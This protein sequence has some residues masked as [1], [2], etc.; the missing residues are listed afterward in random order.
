MRL[1][2][3]GSRARDPRHTRPYGDGWGW[4]AVDG[5]DGG[6]ARG[7]LPAPPGVLVGREA[8]VDRLSALLADGDSPLVTLT[9]PPGVGKT[10]LALAVAARASAG[11]ADGVVFVD[12]TAVREPDLVLPEIAAAAGLGADA[13]DPARLAVV[14]R[15][16]ELLLVLDN[17]EHVLAAA[18]GLATALATCPG[19]RILATSR[20]RLHL[21]AEREVPVAPLALPV[22]ADLADPARVAAAPAVAMLLDRVRRFAPDFA[23]TPENRAA[24]VE[25]CTRLDGLP[26]ALELA[27]AR[28]RL[29]TPSELQFRLARRFDLLTSAVQDGPDRHRTLHAALAWSH[30]LL[31]PFERAVFRR[32]S[33]FVGGWTLPA[34]EAVGLAAADAGRDVVTAVGSLIDKSLVRRRTRAGDVAEFVLLE[35]LREFGGEQLAAHGERAATEARHREHY[36]A[37]GTTMEA[38]LGADDEAARLAELGAEVGNLRAALASATAAGDTGAVLALATAVGWHSYTRGRLGEGRD[39]LGAALAA[40]RDAGVPAGELGRALV[41]TGAIDYARNDLDPAQQELEAGLAEAARAGAAGRQ[42]VATAFLGHVARARGHYA[43]A[44]AHHEAARRLHTA[45]GHSAGVAWSG[46][47]LGLLARHRGDAATA[48]G[49]LR[50]CLGR[51]REL[52][53]AWGV[54]CSAWALATVELGAGRV[55][56]AAA[57]LDEALDRMR[58]Q[59]DGRGQAQC[60]EMAAAVAC[61]RRDPERAALL[62]GAA[63]GLRER[64]GAPVPDEDVAALRDLATR[65]RRSLGPE[66]AHRERSAGRAAPLPAALA[67]ARAVLGDA[68]VPS[69]GVLTAREREVAALVAEGRTNRQIGRALGISE[70]TAEVHVHNIIRKLG[71]RSRAEVAARVVAAR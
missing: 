36:A 12:L 24:L 19:L 40:A 69:T 4:A 3:S 33:V 5:A 32:L 57:L 54:G 13:G 62:L 30:D 49:L 58:W 16:R 64:F 21:R 10:R 45:Q 27:A 9:G 71:A 41:V 18:G 61:A 8:E 48:D 7:T 50:E 52:D 42:A 34:A 43:Q 53:H 38:T 65:V 46:Y 70:K 56:A 14:L 29:F 25:I 6:P 11:F 51:F 28:L 37:L 68:P 59:G 47:D 20:E 22:E 23:V 26:L 1:T 39:R 60:L 17:V 31:D 35:S 15:D 2:R 55:D 63:D 67:L 44:V 66:G